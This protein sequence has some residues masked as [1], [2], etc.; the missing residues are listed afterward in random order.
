ME[1][2]TI[3]LNEALDIFSDNLD[4]IKQ[5]CED[6][7]AHTIA[8]NPKPLL[9]SD[10]TLDDIRQEVWRLRLVN[11]A[12]PLQQVHKRIVG[13]QQHSIRPRVGGVTP[14]D[15]ERAREYPVK[16][17]FEEL[18]GEK[19]RHGMV[20]CPFHDDSSPSMSLQKYNRYHCFG[21]DEKGDTIALYMKLNE[22]NFIQA[23]KK[24]S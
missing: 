5:S 10:D 11:I 9:T 20:H 17:L 1:K 15:I 3:T 12:T 8:T 22:C 4:D 2:S 16:E 19:H 7:L 14:I 6:N 13:R 18:T 23:V 21:C 24:L